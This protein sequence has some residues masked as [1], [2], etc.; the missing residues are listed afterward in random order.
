MAEVDDL[1]IGMLAPDFTLPASSGSSVTLSSYRAKK[2]VYLFFIREYNWLQCRY[3]AGQ[4]GQLYH[5]FQATNCEIVLILGED[6][7]KAKRYVDSLHLP[8]PVLSDPDRKIYHQYGLQK[9]MIFLQRTASIVIDTDGKI[10][11]IR[12]TSSPMVWLQESKELLS[13]VQSISTPA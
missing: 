4:L 2:S 8:Y 6:L 11:Y 7:D 3:H 12:T 5:E 10:R 1:S 9:A 13:A